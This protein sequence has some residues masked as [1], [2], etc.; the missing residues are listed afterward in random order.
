LKFI[1]GIILLSLSLFSSS[2]YESQPNIIFEHKILT[3][4]QQDLSLRVEFNN[5]VLYLEQKKYLKAIKLFKRTA[6]ILKVPSF[7]NIGIAYY[8]L[9][10]INNAYLY[11]KKIYSVKEAATQDTYSYI[12]ASYY[13][14]LITNDRKYISTIL[15]VVTTMNKHKINEHIVILV[16]DTY[17][18][19]KKYEKAIKLINKLKEPNHLKLA[20]LYLKTNDYVK[21]EVHLKKALQLASDD[22]KIN[23]ILW[24]LVFRDLKANDIAKLPD[25]ILKIQDR[26][27]MF[28]ANLKM[29][30]KLYFNPYQYTAEQYFHNVLHFTQNRTIDMIFYFAPF[31]FIDKNAIYTDS[32]LGYILKNKQNIKSLGSMIKYNNKFISLVEDDPIE[33]VAKLQKIMDK[34]YHAK[35]YELYNLALCYAQINDFV[36]AHKY[37]KKAYYLQN[38]NKLYAAMTL[39]SAIRADITINKVQKKKIEINLLSKNG[40]YNYF[41]K[42]IYKI[43][44][45]KKYKLKRVPISRVERKSIFLRALSFLDHLDK[46]GIRADEPLLQVDVKDPLVYL[47]RNLARYKDETQYKYISRL[48]DTIPKQYNNDFLKGPL[49]ITQYYFDVLK[50]LGIFDLVNV[51]IINETSP[52]YLRTKALMQLYKGHPVVSLNILEHLKEKYNLNDNYTSYLLIA[53]LLSAGDYSNAS[54]TLDMLQF[55]RNDKNAKFLNGV[56]LLQSLKLNSAI[57]SFKEKYHGYL[58]DFKLENFN[59]YLESL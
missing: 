46:N 1:L 58:I 42:Y 56:L 24:F 29:P 27:R 4:K 11:L 10:S 41:G 36:N 37:F 14:Y 7:L 44:Y 2:V 19:L 30:L 54:A 48:Q 6:K 39:I 40:N 23:Q 21:A 17:I 43:I 45:D 50:G 55:E 22:K 9:H 33:R 59:Q 31:I 57:S 16:A 12:S 51:D 25:H 15:K 49:I 32:A 26:K 8:K 20:L 53:S 18:L 38:S 28:T 35:S 13:L 52:T 47:L 5:A 34:K 3:K